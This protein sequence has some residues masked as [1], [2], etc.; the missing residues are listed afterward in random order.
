MFH[1]LAELRD[2]P[3]PDLAP[4]RRA[5]EAREPK[6]LADSGVPATL[7]SA[8]EFGLSGRNFYAKPRNPPYWH[9]VPGSIDALLLRPQVGVMLAS[10]DARLARDGLRLFLHDAWRPRAV[11]AYFHDDWFP[12]ALRRQTPS[13]EGEALAMEVRRYWAPPSTADAPAP[14]ATGGAVDVALVWE[15]DGEPLFMGS[16]FDD[17]SSLSHLDRFEGEEDSQALFSHAEARANRR[18][19]YWVMTEA[20]F[21]PLANEWWHY[22]YGDAA[23]ARMVGASEALFGAARED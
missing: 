10:V 23:W 4:L 6:P 22:S 16:L 7:V 17:G 14:H 20:G 11:Q 3:L 2:R 21:C 13:L 12:K 19:L 18:L 15:D 1:H 8:A 9:V 5:W